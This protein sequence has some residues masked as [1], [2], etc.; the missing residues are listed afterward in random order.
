[1]PFRKEPTPGKERRLWQSAFPVLY[2]AQ[3]CA[4][5][6]AKQ[7]DRPMAIA[8]APISAI[9]PARTPAAANAARGMLLLL[10]CP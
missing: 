4:V 2:T 7:T 5:T 8:R 3:K 1:M 10:I 6:I 9:I